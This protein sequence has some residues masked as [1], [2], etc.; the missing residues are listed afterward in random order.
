MVAGYATRCDALLIRGTCSGFPTLSETALERAFNKSELSMPLPGTASG[1][2][3]RWSLRFD[4]I[5][6][7]FNTKGWA[8]SP[9]VIIFKVGIAGSLRDHLGCRT[10]AVKSL[11][12]AT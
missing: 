6:G 4:S 9:L 11:P 7:L 2:G 10:N 12:S 3:R 1:E 5:Y 8:S